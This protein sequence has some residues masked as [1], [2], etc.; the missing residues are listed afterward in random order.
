MKGTHE[1]EPGKGVLYTNDKKQP[2]SKAPDMKGGFTAD[3]DIKQG[4][5]VKLAGWTKQTR[6]GSLISLAQDNWVPDPNYKKPTPGSTVR[7]Y[8]PRFLSDK[9]V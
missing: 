4:E 5:W 3:R 2:G 7:E 8:T 9:E 6:V 1:Q